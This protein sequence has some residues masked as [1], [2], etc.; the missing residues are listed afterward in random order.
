MPPRGE[1]RMRGRRGVLKYMLLIFFHPNS[2]HILVQWMSFELIV[3]LF[4]CQFN[5]KF[6]FPLYFYVHF[7]LNSSSASLIK[8]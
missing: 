4:L 8:G 5:L 3:L 1:E 7:I 2:L 6:P